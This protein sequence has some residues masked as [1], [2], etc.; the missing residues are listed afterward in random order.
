MT[1][2]IPRKEAK[3]KGLT[4][5]FTGKPCRKGHIDYRSYADST[6]FACAREKSAKARKANPELSK[7]ATAAQNKRYSEDPLFRQAAIS[8]ATAW[9]KENKEKKSAYLK[10]YY[11]ANKE[12][13]SSQAKARYEKNRSCPEWVAK[14]RERQAKKHAENP[15]HKRSAV[16]TRRARIKKAEGNHNAKDIASILISQNHRCTYCNTCLKR[17]YVVDH[18]VPLSRGGTNWP[19]NL[20]CLCAEC[21]GRKW[22]KSHEQFLEEIAANKK[23]RQ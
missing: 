16:R 18:I 23:E 2:I 21:N 3:A 12:R 9:A 11:Q 22:C 20:Q 4:R 15:E 7:R 13:A 6:C 14:E 10:S 19:E 1:E 17:G 5:Y 8:R